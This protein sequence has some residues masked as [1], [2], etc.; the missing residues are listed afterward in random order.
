MA[1]TK[2]DCISDKESTFPVCFLLRATSLIPI[3]LRPKTP[4]IINEVYVICIKENFPN[5]SISK[6]LLANTSTKIEKDLMKTLISPF[7]NESLNIALIYS[8]TL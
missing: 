2:N 6:N 4:K 7:H 5:S 1:K 3:E 8:I